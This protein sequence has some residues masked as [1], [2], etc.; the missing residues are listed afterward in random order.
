[1]SEILRHLLQLRMA[2]RVVYAASTLSPL[3]VSNAELAEWP[4]GW[5]GP[6]EERRVGWELVGGAWTEGLDE[7]QGL[8]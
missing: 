7:Q 4:I 5:L 6:D 8:A 1:M 2:R 3:A